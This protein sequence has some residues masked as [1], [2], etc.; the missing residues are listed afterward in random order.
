MFFPS[1]ANKSTYLVA[2][3]SDGV[4]VIEDAYT[5]SFEYFRGR[6]LSD[7]TSI[8][9]VA[10]R[11]KSQTRAEPPTR[12]DDA[13]ESLLDSSATAVEIHGQDNQISLVKR[14]LRALQLAAAE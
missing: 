3:E 5:G 4:F 8:S 9:D 14:P 1:G 7:M 2:Q 11:E 13:W 10:L 6:P 12:S